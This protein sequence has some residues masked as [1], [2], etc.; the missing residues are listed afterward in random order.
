MCAELPSLE[1]IYKNRLNR[2]AS[3]VLKDESHPAKKYFELLTRGQKCRHFK[4]KK[5]FLDSTY[6]QTVKL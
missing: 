2:K 6:P 1:T 3:L 5:R 4:G